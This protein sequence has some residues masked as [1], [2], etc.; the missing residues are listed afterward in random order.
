VRRGALLFV[1][2]VLAH[3]CAV[4]GIAFRQDDRLSFVSPADRDEVTLP[5]TVSWRVEDFDVPED[6][7]YAVFVDRAPQPPGH[8]LAWL[9]RN[10]DSCRSADGC[11]DVSWF[12][13]RDVFPTTD[14]ELKI[15]RLPASTDDRREMH[16]VTVVLLDA[17]GVRVG[18]T[19]WTL[20]VQVARDG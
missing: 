19:G 5:V 6:G 17:D 15:E 20:H 2:A 13:Q 1:L 14:T 3:G 12:S 7:S 4:T 9:A 16:E 11:P 10:D 8:T 18:E